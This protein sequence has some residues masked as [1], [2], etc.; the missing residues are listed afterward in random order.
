MSNVSNEEN[1]VP[2]DNENKTVI[3][4]CLFEVSNF[5][6]VFRNMFK[7]V[8]LVKNAKVIVIRDNQLQIYEE[9]FEEWEKLNTREL[10][11]RAEQ[12]KDKLSGLYL[13]SFE[14]CFNYWTDYDKGDFTSMK[15]INGDQLVL[16]KNG[17]GGGVVFEIV[18]DMSYV[19]FK[20]ALN[21]A[22]EF[23]VFET[24]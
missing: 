17:F 6:D 8:E 9:K 23:D 11:D 5:C 1:E 10:F 22:E 13:G 24:I 18:D 20:Q 7:K 14:H 12:Q 15:L 21:L 4:N 16:K 19:K 2:V 3:I